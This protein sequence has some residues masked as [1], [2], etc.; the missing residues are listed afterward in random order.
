LRNESGE[1][2]NEH[3]KRGKKKGMARPLTIVGE[4]KKSPSSLPLKRKKGIKGR[5]KGRGGGGKRPLP[6]YCPMKKEKKNWNCS[7]A[8]Q[9]AG[10][11]G[12]EKEGGKKKKKGG[13][14]IFDLLPKGGEGRDRRPAFF[15]AESRS[16]TRSWRERGRDSPY[17]REKKKGI[18]LAARTIAQGGRWKRR[19]REKGEL[20]PHVA[21]EGGKGGGT[22]RRS[23]RPADE[24][25]RKGGKREKKGAF[26]I[27]C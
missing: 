16:Q 10:E 2:F 26:P 15:Y 20:L 11:G 4:R 21:E 13:G 25:K 7:E 14:I 8:L 17:G 6:I 12:I 5:E 24:G 22:R 23:R 1:K 3:A 9:D 27:F 19:E 18:F